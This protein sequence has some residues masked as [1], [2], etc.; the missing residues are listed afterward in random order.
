MQCVHF[1][2]NDTHDVAN[3]FYVST[4]DDCGHFR[5]LNIALILHLARMMLTLKI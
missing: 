2:D 3:N 5:E 1:R 4:K